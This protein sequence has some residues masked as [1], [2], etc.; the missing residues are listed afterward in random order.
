VTV[1]MASWPSAC[2]SACCRVKEWPV[3]HGASLRTATGA[4][5]TWVFRPCCPVWVHMQPRMRCSV[6]MKCAFL[7]AVQHICCAS[8][9]AVYSPETL[10]T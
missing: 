2:F 4:T 5:A 9:V 1:T 10:I 7:V 6:N 8:D 3:D